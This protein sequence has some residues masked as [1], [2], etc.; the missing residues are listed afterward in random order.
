MNLDEFLRQRSPTWQQLEKQLTEVKRHSDQTAVE[1]IETLGRLYRLATADLALAQRDF[2]KQKTTYYLNQLVGRAHALIYRSEP[3]GRRQ[4]WR[5]VAVEFPR[6]YRGLLPY[7]IVATALFGL[8]ALVAFAAVWADP[9]VIYLLAGP[10]IAPLVRQVEEG[11]LWTDIA[12]AARSAASAM[13]LTNNIQVTF[14][15]FAGGVTAG[16]LTA[17]V[18]L[19][20]GL[21]L[22]GVF[23]LLQ[24]HGLS[25]GLAE[26]VVAHG[27]VEL[28]VIFA[29]GG[30]G[31]YMGDG[32]LRPGLQ[33]RA[34]VLI[35]RARVSVMIILGCAPLL[36]MA[37]IIEG[38]ISPSGLPWWVKLAVG[39]ITGG[40]LHY[41]WLRAGRADPSLTQAGVAH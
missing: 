23:G 2:P 22:G 21:N 7:T 16:V 15:T 4:L 9:E 34:T 1:E 3:L 40:A 20:N 39:L 17:W 13:I 37:G 14:T 26:F 31:L 12:P 41:Y 38:F 27:F 18:L 30:C 19:F 10:G 11:K 35:Q 33:S 25:A 36:I 32:L 24:A 29:A 5:F 8:A 28:S 6:L